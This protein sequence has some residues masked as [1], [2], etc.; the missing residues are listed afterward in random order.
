M[1]EV[2]ARIA[3]NVRFPS[4]V[5]GLGVEPT[6]QAIAGP[7]EQRVTRDRGCVSESTSGCELPNRLGCLRLFLP[8][9]SCS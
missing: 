1:E 6:E 9:S 4:H 8:T 7:D 2:L 5:A 3:A